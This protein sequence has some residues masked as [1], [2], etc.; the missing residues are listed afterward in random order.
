V[1][2]CAAY[3]KQDRSRQLTLELWLSWRRLTPYLPCGGL[4]GGEAG[5]PLSYQTR[6]PQAQRRQHLRY[7]MDGRT[8]ARVDQPAHPGRR[9]CGR[10]VAGPL[11]PLSPTARRT[12]G[13]VS[14]SYCRT[15]SSAIH[16]AWTLEP[17]R[18]VHR[19]PVDLRDEF[20]DLPSEIGL[21][22]NRRIA[23]ITIRPLTGRFAACGY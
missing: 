4:A 21:R 15:R 16:S 13:F 8:E 9:C 19:S 7:D 10:G 6:D 14:P 23:P 5:P 12:G 1:L 2:L 18:S 22:M 11:S 17:Q 20:C 3:G